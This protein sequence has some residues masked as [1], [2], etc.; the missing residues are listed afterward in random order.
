MISLTGSAEDEIK[1]GE[2]RNKRKVDEGS[3]SFMV[4]V[5]CGPVFE[6]MIQNMNIKCMTTVLYKLIPFCILIIVHD[7][8][9]TCVQFVPVPDDY[10]M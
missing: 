4:A 8:A 3:L 1:N 7:V 5:I 6:N 10:C 9:C 2:I